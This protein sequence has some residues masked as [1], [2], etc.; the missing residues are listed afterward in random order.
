M[1]H[2]TRLPRQARDSE[3]VRRCGGAV[4]RRGFLANST[5]FVFSP[6]VAYTTLQRHSAWPA[7]L[8]QTKR[9]E[10]FAP[11]STS[12][13]P[14]RRRLKRGDG[15]AVWVA[16]RVFRAGVLFRATTQLAQHD[17]LGTNRT[18]VFFFLFSFL[19]V[20]SFCAGCCSGQRWRWAGCGW[21]W[22]SCGAR[23]GHTSRRRSSCA[24]TINFSSAGQLG[25]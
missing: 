16:E 17:R 24:C 1:Q 13:L 4:V 18:K 21:R 2:G 25:L 8:D 7:S 23:H 6:R 12:L 3:A 9:G 15:W 11:R 10:N 19:L 5:G 22:R 14:W 20:F